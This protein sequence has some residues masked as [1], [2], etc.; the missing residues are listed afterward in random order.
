[1]FDVP[2]VVSCFS[3]P[4]AGYLSHRCVQ[5]QG[6]SRLMMSQPGNKG[7]RLF[8]IP[9]VFP[10][11]WRMHHLDLLKPALSHNPL[12]A[13]ADWKLRKCFSFHFI[14][15]IVYIAVPKLDFCWWSCL[16]VT[17][18]LFL[19]PHWQNAEA[20]CCNWDASFSPSI[21]HM[22]KAAVNPST[23]GLPGSHPNNSLLF[24][25]LTFVFEE[26]GFGGGDPESF[27]QM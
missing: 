9:R 23:T 12:R 18:G 13:E 16:N 11:I 8:L 7:W 27:H 15:I 25:S 6:S 19:C 3:S 26:N 20:S 1:M 14:S 4:V 5:I 22:Q 10:V 2:N 21:L 17:S 24:N